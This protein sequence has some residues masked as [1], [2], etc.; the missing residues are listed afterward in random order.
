M[1]IKVYC[2][3]FNEVTNGYQNTLDNIKDSLYELFGDVD[4]AT[5]DTLMEG[6]VANGLVCRIIEVNEY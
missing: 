2:V 3:T 5:D 1:K 6:T 4:I